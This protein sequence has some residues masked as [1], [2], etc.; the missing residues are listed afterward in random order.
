MVRK[1]E[2]AR[3]SAARLVNVQ[4][5]ERT[6]ARMSFVAQTGVFVRYFPL[7]NIACAAKLSAPIA[8][9]NGHGLM[10]SRDSERSGLA[11]PTATP[12]KNQ[13]KYN[14]DLDVGK[15]SGPPRSDHSGAPSRCMGMVAIR[16]TTRNTTARLPPDSADQDSLVMRFGRS[17]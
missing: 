13:P 7:E 6:V 4:Q 11:C 8:S 3:P 2:R 17:W 5:K 9:Q 15:C 1:N 14:K 12:S 16:L 10:F